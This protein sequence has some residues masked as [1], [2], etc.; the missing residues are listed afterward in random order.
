MALLT[1]SIGLVCGLATVVFRRGD[2]G[3]VD[4]H[5]DGIALV[6][7]NGASR[8]IAFDDIDLVFVSIRRTVIGELPIGNHIVVTTHAG[9]RLT[10]PASRYVGALVP[11]LMRRCSAPIVAAGR[12]A[13]AND[14]TL[15]FGPIALNRTA[16][17]ISGRDRPWSEIGRVTFGVD[18][19]SVYDA[20]GRFWKELRLAQ[21]P[22][23]SALATLLGEQTKVEHV[24]P[25]LYTM[26][27]RGD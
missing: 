27:K 6:D 9:A 22:H 15:V 10:L 17:S 14:E 16:L 5:E 1:G 23:A 24:T 7:A 4:L 25:L 19:V 2:R 26:L 12:V 18:L 3:R 11:V 21:I 20:R 8:E 13:I